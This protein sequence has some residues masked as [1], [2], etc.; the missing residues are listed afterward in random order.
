V[1]IIEWGM[2]LIMDTIAFMGYP[3]I[4]GLMALES[5]CFPIPSEVV[6]PFA[7][8]LVFNGTMD[9]LVVTLAGTIGCTIGSI[10]AY[11]VGL[12]GGRPLVCRYGRYLLM[13]EKHLDSAER[14][15]KKYGDYAIFFSRLLPIVRTFISLPAGIARMRFGRFVLLSFAGSLPW[16]F[17]LTY[18]GFALGDGWHEIGEF[19]EGFDL[20]VVVGIVIIAI[21]YIWTVRKRKTC[22]PDDSSQPNE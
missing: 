11:Y 8:W 16:C 12:K 20:L 14:W 17:A 9:L 15:F 2:A 4:V 13:N 5:A 6:M 10:L 22:P 18:A 7:G 3:G 19:L 1:G 21:W